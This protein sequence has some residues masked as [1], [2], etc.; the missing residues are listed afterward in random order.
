MDA[1]RSE[2]AI[3]QEALDLK[4]QNRLAEAEAV[5]VAGLSRFPG[6]TRLK[7]SLADAYVRQKRLGEAEELAAGILRDSPQEAAALIVL[8][9]VRFAQQRYAD[10][11]RHFTEARA[12]APSPYVIRR[13]AD[14]YRRAGA[15]A[16]AVT[17]LDEQLAASPEDS[18]AR[19]ARAA[20][21]A[22]AGERQR[23]IEAYRELVA[24][25]PDDSFSFKEYVRLLTEGQDP[26]RAAAEIERL[27]R[28]ARHAANPHLHAL[29]ADQY[30]ALGAVEKAA[31]HLEQ[32]L[33][34]SPGNL[35]LTKQLGFLY[36]NARDRLP[37]AAHRAIPLLAGAL[38]QDPGDRP[39]RSALAAAYRYSGRQAEGL[40]AFQAIL[41]RHPDARH[42][43][44]EIRKFARELQEME[45]ARQE[46]GADGAAGPDQ[47]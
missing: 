42:L 18:A 13:L 24:A 28:V 34:L 21:L 37:D 32:A 43:W 3:A 6:E 47:P 35:F 30:K 38:E 16:K 23:A 7:A 25:D 39:V 4:R 1:P 14:A 41:A 9:N 17:L 11:V 8:G 15:P 5:L 44:G 26:A 40:A 29:L 45:Q 19:R 10:A 36:Y 22:A 27:M 46:E 20:A 33:A 31:A 12:T 2:Y